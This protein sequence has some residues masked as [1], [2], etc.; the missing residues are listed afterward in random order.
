MNYITK[1]EKNGV[2]LISFPVGSFAANCTAIF[3]INSKRALLIDPGLEAEDT[4]SFIAHNNLIVETILH[5]HGHFD[6]IGCSSE[7]AKTND[8]S[9]YLHPLDHELYFSMKEHAAM[10]GLNIKGNLSPIK[11]NL[12]DAKV[13]TFQGDGHDVSFTTL[14]TPGH[15]QGS[16]SFYSDSFD[17]PILISGDTL[18]KNSI[19]RTDLP[20][21]DYETLITSIKSKLFPLPNE[22]IV[23][24]GHGPSTT[25]ADEKK[26]NPFLKGI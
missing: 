3:D 14:H 9:L 24:T 22:T 4:V 5:T 23:I 7:I 20:G 17:T 16:C 10:F 6:H 15:S 19:G 21:G 1:I 12:A 18:F 8:A 2:K 25:I 26:F 11:Y 13:I